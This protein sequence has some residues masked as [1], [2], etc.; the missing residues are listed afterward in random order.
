MMVGRSILFAFIVFSSGN[1]NDFW[2][3][4]RYLDSHHPGPEGGV[5]RQSL[6]RK[7]EQGL[8]ECNNYAG[9][10]KET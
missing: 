10:F 6:Q 5:P 2:K 4:P 7:V 3:K 1:K 8:K 9:L